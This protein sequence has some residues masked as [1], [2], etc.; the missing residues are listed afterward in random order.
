MVSLGDTIVGVTHDPVVVTRGAIGRLVV[1]EVFA[2]YDSV[3]V[4]TFTSS[5]PI[6]SKF[7]TSAITPSPVFE[8]C[9]VDA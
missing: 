7:D 5:S 8:D 2:G 3:L 6:S 4:V 1:R 9:E